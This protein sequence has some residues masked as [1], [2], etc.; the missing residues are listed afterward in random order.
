M[1]RQI[2]RRTEII[3]EFEQLLVLNRAK[4]YIWNWCKDCSANARMLSPEIAAREENS[5]PRNI[6]RLVETGKLHFIEYKDGS[7]LICMNSFRK[8][9]GQEQ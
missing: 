4:N 1:N 6:Y 2:K 8:D 3:I 9:R 7:L 5:T